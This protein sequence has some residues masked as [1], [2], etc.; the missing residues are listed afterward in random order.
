MSRGCAR[1]AGIAGFAGLAAWVLLVLLRGFGCA[2]VRMHIHLV[3]GILLDGP[4]DGRASGQTKP[5]ILKC[6]DA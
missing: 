3:K 1:F 2:S 4:T 6:R 5:L